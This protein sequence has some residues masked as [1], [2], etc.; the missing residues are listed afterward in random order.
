MEVICSSET[1]VEFQWTAWRYILEGSTIH[2][3]LCDNI[4]SYITVASLKYQMPSYCE[5]FYTYPFNVACVFIIEERGHLL[6]LPCHMF[7]I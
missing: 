6:H 4:K 1:A 7:H 3:H 5:Q 2:N